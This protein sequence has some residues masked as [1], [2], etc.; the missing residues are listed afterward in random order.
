MIPL[1][2]F[3]NGAHIKIPDI[4]ELFLSRL[5]SY[6]SL[7]SKDVH[8]RF[9]L[10]RLAM[11]SSADGKKGLYEKLTRASSTM[12]LDDVEL[13]QPP[14]KPARSTISEIMPLNHKSRIFFFFAITINTLLSIITLRKLG[15]IAGAPPYHPP[16]IQALSEVSKEAPLAIRWTPPFGPPPLLGHLG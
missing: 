12:T 7:A 3:P 15:M 14:P 10:F 5:S 9:N 2:P 1:P 16:H 11:S 4:I 8:Q 13:E 6:A